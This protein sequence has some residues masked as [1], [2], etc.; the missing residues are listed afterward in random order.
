MSVTCDSSVVFSGYSD[1]HDITEILLNTI[2]PNPHP[3][4]IPPVSTKQTITYHHIS[5]NIKKT[6]TNDVRNPG[7]G[8]RQTQ[9]C[10][11]FKPVNGI[12]DHI[13]EPAPFNN[14]F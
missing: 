12:S 4:T 5:L 7:P 8:L 10:T 3:K 1:N 2:T 14:D 6:V 9:K 13:M 11:G